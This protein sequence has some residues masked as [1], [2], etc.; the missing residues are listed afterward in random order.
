[1]IHVCVQNCPNNF[2]AEQLAIVIRLMKYF[3]ILWD[4]KEFMP[5]IAPIFATPGKYCE[6]YRTQSRFNDSF[7]IALLEFHHRIGI[8]AVTMIFF[9]PRDGASIVVYMSCGV[10]ESELFRLNS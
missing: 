10:E 2:I 1:M 9:R 8:F 4:S 7:S 5:L 3:T 6:K